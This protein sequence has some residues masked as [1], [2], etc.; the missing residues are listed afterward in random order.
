[1]REPDGRRPPA[2]APDRPHP[3]QHP[4]DLD[5]GASSQPAPAR[6][7]DGVGD[8]DIERLEASLRWL[9]RQQM[10]TPPAGAA[11]STPERDPARSAAADRNGTGDVPAAG[12]R[13]PRSLEPVRM[14]PPPRQAARHN[15]R[16]LA[17]M[18]IAVGVVAPVAYYL[19][20]AQSPQPAPLSQP[21]TFEPTSLV[22]QT[23]RGGAPWPTKAQDE[24]RPDWSAPVVIA[25]TAAAAPT[26]EREQAVAALRP[27]EPP[28]DA[29]AEAPVALN[30]APALPAEEIALLLQ[31]GE[32][33]I[34][35]GDV[36]TARMVLQRAAEAGDATAAIALGATYDPLVLRKLGV[37]GM[38]GDVE[39]ARLWYQRAERLGSPEA[40]RR[41][42]LLARR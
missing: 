34:A 27:A 28:A 38:P 37:I 10:T 31:Q 20:A 1:M 42:E 3:R 30:P 9:R 29:G 40:Q 11:A 17:H 12:L 21:V 18:L 19:L 24:T 2:P 26:P 8:P 25:T 33:F 32:Q 15:M 14:P 23:T 4:T 13:L 41:L 5:A 7:S 35:A 16:R 22:P 36:V 6:E 39:Q